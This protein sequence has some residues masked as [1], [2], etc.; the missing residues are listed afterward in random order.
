MRVHH[1]V[2]QLA[3]TEEA[4]GVFEVDHIRMVIQREDI[5]LPS[6]SYNRC[7]Y[8]KPGRLYSR[9]VCVNIYTIH[10]EL[11]LWRSF[12]TEVTYFE[13]RVKPT[14]VDNAVAI[15]VFQLIEKTILPCSNAYEQFL[16][17]NSPITPYLPRPH[18]KAHLYNRPPRYC[19]KLNSV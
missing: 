13:V 6:E 18:G 14:G 12:R 2:A 3:I 10:V 19:S 16:R 11:Q 17:F 15:S 5:S 7:P 9:L 1:E 4:V 8:V